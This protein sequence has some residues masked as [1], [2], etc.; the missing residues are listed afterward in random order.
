[1]TTGRTVALGA[2][3]DDIKRL[4]HSNLPLLLNAHQRQ[5]HLAFLHPAFAARGKRNI[6]SCLRHATS[7]LGVRGSG[8][9][10]LCP[11][12]DPANPAAGPACSRARRASWYGKHCRSRCAVRRSSCVSTCSTH[13]LH[14]TVQMQA[15]SLDK[16]HA[17]YHLRKHAALHAVAAA[18]LGQPTWAMASASLAA[19]ASSLPGIGSTVSSDAKRCCCCCC[20]CCEAGI[21]P[22]CS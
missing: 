14:R 11:T 6:T 10:G 20:C 2:C 1:M 7:S 12:R 17:V 9:R 13:I 22:C 19:I 15:V 16:L 5:H 3:H 4:A 21:C 8:T 18:W